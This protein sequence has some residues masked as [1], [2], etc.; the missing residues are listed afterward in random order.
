MPAEPDAIL[1]V[2]F[3]TAEEGGRKTPCLVGDR[4]RPIFEI[5]GELHCG[6]FL[7]EGQWVEPGN[8][9]EAP[10]AFLRPDF[11]LPK[12]FA[13]KSFTIREVRAMATCKVIRVLRK[14]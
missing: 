12:L 9:C 7:G 13:G 2:R 14:P 8:S 10:V 4:Y 11:V 6:R 1:E 5:D 3:L